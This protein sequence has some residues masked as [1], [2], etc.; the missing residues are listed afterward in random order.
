MSN[1]IALRTDMP[2]CQKRNLKIVRT[3]KEE[4][5]DF[6]KLNWFAKLY[7]NYLK[8]Q[9][10]IKQKKIKELKKAAYEFYLDYYLTHTKG[11]VDIHESLYRSGVAICKF[12]SD[13][14]EMIVMQRVKEGHLE[15]CYKLL[16]K[17]QKRQKH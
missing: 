1:V 16:R 9:D 15:K 8:R 13:M 11:T 14:A 5:I 3:Q 10:E 12:A 6:H 4:K 2:I 7:Q 17:T